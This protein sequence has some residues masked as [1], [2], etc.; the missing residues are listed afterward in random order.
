MTVVEDAKN[1]TVRIGA[2]YWRSL[3]GQRRFPSRDDLTLRGMA[4]ILPHSVIVGVVDGGADYEFRY[5]GDGQRQ[6]YKAY[7]KGM[8][9][10]RIETVAPELGQVLRTVYEMLRS[11]GTP[12]LLRGKADYEV[13]DP[14]HRYHETA[15]LPLGASDAAVD[16]LLVV[17]VHVPAPFWN[18]SADNRKTLAAQLGLTTFSA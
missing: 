5:V 3:R 14:Q 1:P 4:A 18:L 7:F 13:I 16:H 6:A 9:L 15:L 10:S 2:E 8:R 11:T 17:G 12:F